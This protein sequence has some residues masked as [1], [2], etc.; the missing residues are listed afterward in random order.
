MAYAPPGGMPDPQVQQWF[1]AVDQDRSGRITASELQSALMSSNGQKFSETACRLMIG[2]FDKDGTGS[3][4]ITGF[5]HLFAYVNQWLSAFR[6][7]DR[8]Q[9]G[10]INS[11]ELAAALQTMGYRFSQQFV[12]MLSAKFGVKTGAGIPVD[13]F[14]M[15]CIL[16]QKFTDGFRQKDA[17]QQG[18]I[19]INY[20][21][22]LSVILNAWV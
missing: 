7:Y 6:A 4:D 21:D 16:I 15:A 14:I 11:Q 18:V 2:L 9:S 17:Q 10:L 12:D 5:Q 3:I 19:T 20:E 13:G 22:F 1:N 8:D